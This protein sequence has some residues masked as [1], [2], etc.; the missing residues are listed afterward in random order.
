[1]HGRPP[2]FHVPPLWLTVASVSAGPSAMRSCLLALASL[3]LIQLL[4]SGTFALTPPPAT[5]FQLLTL[6]NDR[7]W[8][9]VADAST[10][11]SICATTTV[12]GFSAGGVGGCTC[13]GTGTSRST[14]TCQ[15]SICYV[16]SGTQV[17]AYSYSNSTTETCPFDGTDCCTY[18]LMKGGVLVQELT[19]CTCV[20]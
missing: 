8:S 9:H 17:W 2:S 20:V 16:K 18:M 1:M 15:C 11:P 6:R 19:E 13:T 4:P 14:S 5:S 10:C 7:P 3:L 12:Y